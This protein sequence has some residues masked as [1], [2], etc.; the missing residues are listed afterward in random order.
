MLYFQNELNCLASW[1]V[2]TLEVDRCHQ[3]PTL[4]KTPGRTVSGKLT[5]RLPGV[6]KH[7]FL[8]KNKKSPFSSTG[9]RFFQ[10][11]VPGR[12]FAS[13]L[14]ASWKNQLGEA[15][16]GR[17]LGK[18][19]VFAAPAIWPILSDF[20][21]CSSAKT[22]GTPSLEE[23]LEGNPEVWHKEIRELAD[24]QRK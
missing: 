17:M 3:S 9:F 12:V 16:G 2:Q 24:H 19:L 23:S 14:E 18:W 8:E 4:G 1:N 10:F 20:E 5:Q 11:D 22:A 15:G 7:T 6:W 21:V 13:P